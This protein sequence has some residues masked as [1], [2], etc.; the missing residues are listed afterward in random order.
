[1]KKRLQELNELAVKMQAAP[2]KQLSLTDPDARSMKTRGTGIVGYNVQT[3]V[4]AKH[5]LIVAH[6]VTNVGSDR[7]QLS[8]MAKQAS[9]AMGAKK[10]T[11]I[12]DGGISKAKKF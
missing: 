2:D 12:A 5:H 4:D 3:A 6:E 7:S 9:T 8:T 10:I 1:M 11:V